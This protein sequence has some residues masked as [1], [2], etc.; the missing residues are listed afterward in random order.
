MLYSQMS[1]SNQV[2]IFISMSVCMFTYVRFVCYRSNHLG[3]R[4]VNLGK[5]SFYFLVYVSKLSENHC[6]SSQK[7]KAILRQNLNF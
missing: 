7:P 3:H 6:D 1:R 4:E 2:F 5:K